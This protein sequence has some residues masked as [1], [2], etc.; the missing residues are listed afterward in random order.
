MG[1]DLSQHTGEFR[2]AIQD[3]VAAGVQDFESVHTPTVDGID[4]EAVSAKE[5]K[6]SDRVELVE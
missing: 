2:V 4:D 6:L 5:V 1:L 3:R